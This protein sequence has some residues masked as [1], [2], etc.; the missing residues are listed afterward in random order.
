[1]G[2]RGSASYAS[3]STILKIVLT[4]LTKRCLR[5]DAVID[6]I[7][8]DDDDDDDKTLGIV[9]ENKLKINI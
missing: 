3:T 5:T 2:N 8:Y 9:I 1:M 6:E 4:C 7:R